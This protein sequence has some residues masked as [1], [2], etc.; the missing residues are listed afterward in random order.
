MIE[1]TVRQWYRMFKDG[2]T[3]VHDEERS[4]RPSVVNEVLFKVLTDKFVKVGTSQFHVSFH[5][6]HALSSMR[7]SQLG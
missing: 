1:G 2:R 6:F 7:L 3:N 5:K 4:G